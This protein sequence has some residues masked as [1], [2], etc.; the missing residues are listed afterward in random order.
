MEIEIN[1][2]SDLKYVCRYDFP[3]RFRV[4]WKGG[5]W[6]R[7]WTRVNFGGYQSEPRQLTLSSDATQ[8]TRGKNARIK[9]QRLII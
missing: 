9:R 2:I 6:G 3:L 5:A 7:M 4:T 8:F 1:T